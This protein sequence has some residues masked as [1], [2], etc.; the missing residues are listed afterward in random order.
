[1]ANSPVSLFGGAD[2]R[3]EALLQE[4][5]A[6]IYDRAKGMPIPSIIGTLRILEL[7]I[8]REQE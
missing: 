2:L 6:V 3:C 4:L 1:M 8:I 7:E 5:K